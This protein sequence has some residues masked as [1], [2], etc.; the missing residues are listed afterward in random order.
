MKQ[1][2]SKLKKVVIL[3]HASCSDGFGAA[4]AAWRRF[5]SRASYLPISHHDIPSPE[6]KGKELYFIDIVLSEQAMKKLIAENV[7]VTAIDHHITAEKVVKKTKDYLYDISHSGAVLAWKYFHPKAKTPQI[8]RYVEDRDLWTFKIA[9]TKEVTTA[10]ELLEY[11]FKSWSKFAKE[12]E[13]E[14][15][16]K[17]YAEIGLY[18]IQYTQKFV[19]ELC[20]EAER[21]KFAGRV[22][23]AI[24]SPVFHSEV[25]GAL[26]SRGKSPSIIWSYRKG[27]VRVSLRS[28]GNANVAE[29]AKRFGGG[30]HKRASGFLLDAKKKLPWERI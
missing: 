28:N 11:D 8:L 19:D 13:G 7:R 23:W 18:L 27:R 1:K 17:Y 29:I 30:G 2:S 20:G 9:R 16:R 5:G 12:I 3:Y 25:G 26:S 14:K 10:M 22:C 21:V 15:K 4:W 24:N 6:L